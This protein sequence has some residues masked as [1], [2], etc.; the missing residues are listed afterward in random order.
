MEE[1][2]SPPPI[3]NDSPKTLDSPAYENALI[4]TAQFCY[5]AL[6]LFLNGNFSYSQMDSILAFIQKILPQN[7]LPTNYQQLLK[8][9]GI[10]LSSIRY[11]ICCPNYC[12]ISHQHWTNR[13]EV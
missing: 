7:K 13:V 6:D 5:M 3:A 2:A 8:A 9:V 4:S 10:T 1:S 11:Y 12:G